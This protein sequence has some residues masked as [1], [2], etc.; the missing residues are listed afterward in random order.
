M[1]T[2]D[3]GRISLGFA[4]LKD[5]RQFTVENVTGW[6]GINISYAPERS[7]GRDGQARR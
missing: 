4:D 3:D 2:F 1:R 5:G 6:S 7:R